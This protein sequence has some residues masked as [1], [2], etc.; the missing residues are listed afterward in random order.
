MKLA[1]LVLLLVNIALFAWQQGLFG[2]VIEA[3]R[4]PQ[5]VA[6]QIAPEKLR[7]LTP[8]QLAALR[9]TVQAASSEAPGRPACLEFGDFDESSVERAQARLAALALGERLTSRRVDAAGWFIV[10]LPPQKTRA[11]AE[12]VAQDLRGRGVRDLVV[13]GESS[14]LRNGIALGSFRDQEL[15]RR[16]QG[17]LERRGIEDVR[18]SER[19]SATAV[20]RFEI[21]EVDAVLAQQLADIQKAF[22]QSQLGA[23]AN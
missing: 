23:C 17:D 5:R 15:A 20:T 9:S 11:D 21:R 8:D 14:P 22:P 2:A 3:G 16:Y 18:V 13:L 12:R 1:F 6:R 10:H 7:V 4:E 19:T